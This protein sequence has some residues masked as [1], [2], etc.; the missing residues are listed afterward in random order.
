MPPR[1]PQCPTGSQVAR[2][3]LRYA[4]NGRGHCANNSRFG[5]DCQTVSLDHCACRV[6]TALVRTH[7]S[8]EAGVVAESAI[9]LW[10]DRSAPR[11][12]SVLE[13][14]ADSARASGAGDTRAGRCFRIFVGG[15]FLADPLSFR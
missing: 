9:Q 13:T 11:A 14:L 6:R 12:L 2:A 7:Q 4:A 8:T 1:M 10:P 15:A 3:R 5:N